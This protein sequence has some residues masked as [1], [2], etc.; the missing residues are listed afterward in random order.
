M[1]QTRFH[2][3]DADSRECLR[4]LSAQL[5]Q[6]DRCVCRDPTPANALDLVGDAVLVVDLHGRILYFN[7][8]AATLTGR[9]P[10]VVVGRTCWDAVTCEG[11]PRAIAEAA[12][13]L[14]APGLSPSIL[15]QRCTPFR[16]GAVYDR[17]IALLHSDGRRRLL[18]KRG[19]ALRDGDGRF[20]GAVE[21]LYDVTELSHDH[22]VAGARLDELRTRCTMLEA[23][24]ESVDHGFVAVAPDGAVVCLS[25]RAAEL[26]GTSPDEARGES[27]TSY[28]TETEDLARTLD[29]VTAGGEPACIVGVMPR[30][31]PTLGVGLSVRVRPLRSED[32]AMLGAALM[33]TAVPT[34]SAA[35]SFHGIVGVSP[36]TLRLVATVRSLADR[37]VTVLLTGESGTGK[38]VVARALHLAGRRASRPFHAFNCAALSEELLESELFGHERGA[39]TGATRQKLGRLELCGDGTLLLDEVGCLTPSAQAKLLRVLETREFERVGGSRLLRLRAR[40]IAATN[41]DLAALVREGRFREDLYY[42]LCVVPVEVPPLRAHAED[43]APLARHFAAQLAAGCGGREVHFTERGVRALERYG[44]PGNV[45]ELRN[46]IQFALSIGDGERIDAWD[47]P[48]QVQRAGDDP[49]AARPACDRR[50]IEWALRAADNNRETTA[51]MLGISRTTLWRRMREHG[52][53]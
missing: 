19:R 38:E 15:T 35:G 53:V 10:E 29:Q 31:A 50:A 17:R 52:L 25:L 18:L 14:A 42:R 39:F 5:G 23:L 40:I 49:P 46:A 22:A 24:A 3:V 7:E 8:R 28:L 37:D 4:A 48:P 30:A 41:A 33:L 1:T 12:L 43:I 47:L 44:W 26:L 13:R 20:V 11:C 2:A 21:T 27:I 36:A 16:Q 6:A 34:P 45:R 51:T 32:G 9:D